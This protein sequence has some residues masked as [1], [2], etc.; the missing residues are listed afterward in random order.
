MHVL[1]QGQYAPYSQSDQIVLLVTALGHLLQEVPIQT[2]RP[3]IES[4]LHHF[5]DD[6][7]DLMQAL[8]SHGDLTDD[9][10]A[11]ILQIA[12]KYLQDR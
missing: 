2:I 4:L 8:S 11:E 1:R 10:K 12:K 6:H 5:H 7:P 3:K 9:M